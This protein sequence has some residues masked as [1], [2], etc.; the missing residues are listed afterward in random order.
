MHNAG[1]RKAECESQKPATSFPTLVSISPCAKL[2]SGGT[3]LF[4]SSK[5]TIPAVGNGA[6]GPCALP[7]DRA[8]R[9]NPRERQAMVDVLTRQSRGIGVRR[10]RPGA[11]STDENVRRN[12]PDAAL[13]ELAVLLKLLADDTRLQILYFLTQQP[14][15]NV[16][17]LC[18]LLG[19]SQ[20]AVSHHLALLKNARLLDRRRDGKHNYYA[21]QTGRIT[22]M[23]DDLF[24]RLPEQQ[25]RLQLADYVLTHSPI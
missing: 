16:R 3:H 25:R 20:P 22:A 4:I 1:G 17:A 23:L 14:E 12:M 21:L 15:L 2:Q 19:Q 24:A 8:C 10:R 18:N 11:D 13:E 7:F 5:L 6:A 9:E